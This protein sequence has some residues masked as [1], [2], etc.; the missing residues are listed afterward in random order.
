MVLT[1]P[2]KKQAAM[3]SQTA[4]LSRIYRR[5]RPIV[6]RKMRYHHNAR[7]RGLSVRMLGQDSRVG[8][9]SVVSGIVIVWRKQQGMLTVSCWV[10]GS[11]YCNVQCCSLLQHGLFLLVP[12]MSSWRVLVA[13]AIGCAVRKWSSSALTEPSGAVTLW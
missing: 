12:R 10:V 3:S 7:G 5:E 11:V 8:M 9:V 2:C 6:R 4:Y 13:L 1:S